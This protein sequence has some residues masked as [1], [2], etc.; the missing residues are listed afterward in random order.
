[1]GSNLAAYTAELG[2]KAPIVVFDDA[3]LESAVNG[4][5]F[6]SFIASGQTCVSGTRLIIQSGIYEEF[7]ERFLAKVESIR[8]R[9]GD[10]KL[11]FPK[12]SGHAYSNCD[13]AMNPAS[14]M[15]TIISKNH[16]QRIEKMVDERP[17]QARILA[18][19]E[20]LTGEST[21]DEFDF[22]QG[23]FYPP[24]VIDGVETHDE[25]WR[26]EVFGP[27]VVVKK[28]KVSKSLHFLPE[29]RLIV[30]GWDRRNPKACF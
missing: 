21:L 20:R 16:L 5:A 30:D 10:R 18:G 23:L 19:G 29:T 12:C 24:T 25:L 6:A 3:D 11:T 1:V 26:E 27:V 4:A 9:M 7:M 2:G 14:T 8:R 22:S 17:A 28:F 13:I 15:G